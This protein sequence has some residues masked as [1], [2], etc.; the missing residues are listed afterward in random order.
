MRVL[1]DTHA[2]LWSL[3]EP[4]RLGPEARRILVEPGTEA[5]LSPISVWEA[6]LLAERGRIAVADPPTFVSAALRRAPIREATLTHEIALRSRALRTAHEDPADRF[7]AATADVL[8]LTLL[9]ADARL[10]GVPGLAVLPAD[11]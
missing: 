7:L 6:S 5:W 2:W 9:T 10:L 11:R 3:L 1:L 4:E 8:G